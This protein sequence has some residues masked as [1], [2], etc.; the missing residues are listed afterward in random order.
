MAGRGA[1]PARP[2]ATHGGFVARRSASSSTTWACTGSLPSSIGSIRVRA[3]PALHLQFIHRA[4]D[5]Q[6]RSATGL[7][8]LLSSAMVV[9]PALGQLELALALGQITSASHCRLRHAAWDHRAPAA[10]AAAGGDG[11]SSVAVAG[12]AQRGTLACCR[13]CCTW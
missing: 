10:S 12:R 3:A 9:Q 4:D 2:A 6:P 5:A 8:S 11:L 7:R 1:G 13:R